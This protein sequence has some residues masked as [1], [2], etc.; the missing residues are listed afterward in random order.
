MLQPQKLNSLAT[1]NTRSA[2]L[3]PQISS[4][5]TSSKNSS[6]GSKSSSKLVESETLSGT[7]THKTNSRKTKP[8][9]VDSRLNHIRQGNDKETNAQINNNST[10]KVSTTNNKI[11]QYQ[12]KNVG[13]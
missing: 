12:Q 4:S 1:L 8:Q 2:Q 10:S 9:K 3:L 6:I 11:S 5:S 13:K 7:D